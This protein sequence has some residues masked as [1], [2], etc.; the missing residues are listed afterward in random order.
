[1]AD[2]VR[3][4]PQAARLRGEGISDVAGRLFIVRDATRPIPPHPANPTCRLCA[5]PHTC[6]TYHLQLDA[7]GTVMVSTTIWDNMQ[8]LYDRG[9]FEPVNV[10]A[11]PP[12][13]AIVLPTATVRATPAQM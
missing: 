11:E 1:M 4:Q 10:V 5:Q 6:K 9:G 13:Q 2:G 3:I 12:V 8:R 7:E